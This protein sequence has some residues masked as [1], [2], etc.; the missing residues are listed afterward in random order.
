MLLL[1]LARQSAGKG[2]RRLSTSLS[3]D[4]RVKDDDRG[5]SETAHHGYLANQMV[6]EAKFCQNV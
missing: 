5:E 2:T 1:S 3:A 6:V 4:L